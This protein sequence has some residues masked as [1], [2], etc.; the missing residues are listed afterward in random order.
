MLIMAA[1]SNGTPL[2]YQELERW[3]RVGYERGYEIAT[4]GAMIQTGY[5]S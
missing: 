5:I 2:N 4:R 3:A 1:G